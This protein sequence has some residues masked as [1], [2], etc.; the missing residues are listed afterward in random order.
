MKQKIIFWIVLSTAIMMLFPW[1]AV[2]FIKGDG[3]MA[4]CF[5]LFFAVN[6][7]YSVVIGAF[8]GKNSKQL[9]YLPII[10][11]ILFLL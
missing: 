7:I 10:S 8:A 4:A 6:P 5:T 3:G 9:W 2:T 11:A 1:I